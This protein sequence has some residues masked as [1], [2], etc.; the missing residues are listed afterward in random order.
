[1]TWVVPKTL[2]AEVG[3]DP[4]PWHRHLKTAWRASI[5][6]ARD[7][8]LPRNP[9]ATYL[10]DPHS[11]DEHA[12]IIAYWAPIFQLLVF[13]LGWPRPDVGLARWRE[14]GYNQEDP[15]LRTVLRWW[16]KEGVVDLIAWAQSRGGL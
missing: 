14:R 13:G 11:S 16:G 3:G 1:M 2:H 6:D 12:K 7:M 4:G 9:K 5:T 10:A 15:I 8:R